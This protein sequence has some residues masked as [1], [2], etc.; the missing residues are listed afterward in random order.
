[1]RRVLLLLLLSIV[2]SALA[3]AEPALRPVLRTGLT[4]SVAVPGQIIALEVTILVPTWMLKPP[5][6]P[7]FELTDVVVRLPEGASRPTMERIGRENWSGVTRAYQLSPMVVGRFR[8]PPQIVTV[9]YADPQTRAP[10]VA[11]LRMEEIVFEGRAPAGAEDL[12]P[13]IA[14][15]ALTLEQEIEGDPENLEPGSVF[16]RI[17]TARITGASPIFLPPLIPPLVADGL[18][19][20]PKEPIFNQT[21]NRGVTTGERVERVTYVAEA[22]GR[23]NAQPIRLR[24]WNLRTKEIEVAEVPAIE[25]VSRGPPPAAPSVAERYELAPWLALCGLLL[26]L[27]GAVARWS[28]PRV[29]ERRRRRREVRLASESFAFEQV[30]DALRTR[31]FGD[32][33]RAVELWSTRLPLLRDGDRTRLFELLGPLGAVL[34]GR[35]RQSPSKKQW[36]EALAAL[37]AT[38]RQVLASSR[39]RES[40]RV[41]PSLNPRRTGSPRG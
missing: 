2:C 32:A 35:D 15:E 31:R 34:Y 22:G 39:S 21:A 30:T 16:T 9:T 11:E 26:A 5:E 17:V 28:W 4:T 25:I 6:F 14:A 1:M 3:S 13:F 24:W 18:A 29:A 12:D 41:L 36:S 33:L 23:F 38:R 37:R 40:D 19:A 27:A 20:Y 7:S 8:I 10:I